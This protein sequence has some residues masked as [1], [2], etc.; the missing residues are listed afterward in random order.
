MQM[1]VKLERKN[2]WNFQEFLHPS[3]I[4]FW[5]KF[6][7]IKISLLIFRQMHLFF[8]FFNH[9]NLKFTMARENINENFEQ[10]HETC[11][12][13]NHEIFIS[14]LISKS[15]QRQ[16]KFLMRPHINYLENERKNWKKLRALSF[17]SKKC[18]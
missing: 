18:L 11:L 10:I 9:L 6:C 3:R 12:P 17:S 4:E 15:I 13:I 7:D 5:S 2:A 1:Q 16:V 14:W 8:N